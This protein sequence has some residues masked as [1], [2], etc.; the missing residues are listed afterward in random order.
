MFAH[1]HVHSSYSFLQALPGPRQLAEAISKSGQSGAALT[2]S[3][4]VAGLVEWFDELEKK[5]LRPVVGCELWIAESRL[6]G[7]D[8]RLPLPG[9]QVV[10]IA[11]TLEGWRGLCR[12][13]TAAHRRFDYC[14][15]TTLDDLRENRDGLVVLTGAEYGVTL[16]PDRALERT[17]ALR[18]AIGSSL[19]VEVFDLGLDGDGGR[20]A[21]ARSVAR[22]LSLP[23][24]A[25]ND[26]RY[27][28]PVEAAVLETTFQIAAGRPPSPE[29][30]IRTD[31]AYLKTE[32]EMAELFP[33]EELEESIR[34]LESCDFSP[35]RGVPM[36]PRVGGTG[37]RAS[38]WKYVRETFPPPEAFPKPP[39]EPPEEGP[40][41]AV[42]LRWYARE[43]LRIRLREHPET[44]SFA[45][46]EDHW[47]RLEMEL[48]VITQ[49]EY[50]TYH[51]IVAEFI[52]WAK[53]AGIQVGP[54]R[55]S[56]AGAIVCWALRITDCNPIQ[57]GLLF[58]RFLNPERRGLPDI[59]VDF[60]QARRE[61]VVVHVQG[62]Y[63]ADRVGQILTITRL[64][65]KSA[66][67]DAARVLGISFAEADQ[68]A[69]RI[70]E[71]PKVKLKD[72]LRDPYV[73]LARKCSPTHRRIFD[74]A[75][76]LEGIPRQLG[77]HAAG[78]IVAS[79][80]LQTFCPL[81]WNAKEGRLCVGLDMNS[82][83]KIGLVKFD[84]L[85]LKTLDVI[86]H[87]R[88]SVERRTGR[89]PAVEDPLYDDPDV[90]RMTT[91][92]DTL[93]MFQIESPGMIRLIRKMKPDRFDDLIAIL[94]LFRPGPLQSGMVDDYVERKHGRQETVH[95][96]K[97][98]E[99]TMIPTHGIMIYQEQALTSA[100][101]LAGY[102]YGEADLL[103]RAIGKKKAD[104]MAQQKG[105]FISGCEKNGI[106][107]S[108]AVRIF[109]L[110]DYFSGY[111]FNKCLSGS[112]LV[113]RAGAGRNAESPWISI[114]ELYE[115]QQS[116][117]PWGKKIRSGRLNLAQ[118]NEDARV[119]VGKMVRIYKVGVRPIFRVTTTHKT[120][121]GTAEHRLLS[122]AGY[123]QIGEIRPGETKLVCMGEREGY[124]RVG[125]KGR[126]KGTSY[127]ATEDGPLP[128]GEEN[129]G[130]IDGRHVTKTEAF[131]IVDTRANGRCE[132]CGIAP[133]SASSHALEHAHV[134]SLE[135]CTGNFDLYHSAENLLLLCNSCHKKFDYQK[136][137]RKARWSKGRPTHLEEVLSVEP[138]GETT[139][140]D[141]EME[142]PD[143][144][145]VA[146]GIISHNSH[147]AAYALITYQTAKL[148]VHYRADF[149]AAAMTF[150]A[151]NRGQLRAYVADA[152]R[153]G[154]SVLG[155][156]V[157]KSE[158]DFSVEELPSGALAVRYGLVAVK[159]LGGAALSSILTERRKGGPYRSIRDLADRTRLNKAALESV[160]WSGAADGIEPSRHDAWW[161]IT[162]PSH[163][164]LARGVAPE[165]I[166]LFS[167]KTAS[168][169]REEEIDEGRPPPPSFARRMMLEA[170]ALGTILSDHPL[171]RYRDVATRIR[172]HEIG[173]CPELQS[174]TPVILAG[175]VED[176]VRTKNKREDPYA[177]FTL[178]DGAASISAVIRGNAL[179]RI[180]KQHKIEPGD[181][182]RVEGTVQVDPD[183][184][185][186]LATAIEPLSATRER[187][188]RIL[189]ISIRGR[190]GVIR[191]AEL[192]GG[193]L[194][195]R[196]STS[197]AKIRIR[198][199]GEEDGIERV[200]ELPHKV[201]LSE[202]DLERIDEILGEPGSV[203]LPGAS[204]R[205]QRRRSG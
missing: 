202:E 46:E 188:S 180:E 72:S 147:S 113:M 77:V 197:G 49:M 28:E 29:G 102:S 103:R 99:E 118:M 171:R 67:K 127:A 39:S 42:Y 85:G 110:I 157:N 56:A 153:A 34:I 24:V 158:E 35:K 145:F 48:G 64:K 73:D 116:R 10:L 52:N 142:G 121:E 9:H 95:I 192:L 45:S 19:W 184:C 159:G 131:A 125:W 27:L 195:E 40:V 156:D 21:L 43:G 87:A 100:R 152:R 201:K 37:D 101:I 81:Q 60:E 32:A 112:T 139:V 26:V 168:E 204:K 63:G 182:L 94:A 170:T 183:S 185:Q 16:D 186:L 126:G 165:Q 82:A 200:A 90:F 89:R 178:E 143:H 205:S 93:G 164:R 177:R 17:R 117:T 83:E 190:A 135:D 108:E 50:S 25:T 199:V 18:D 107:E 92:A 8:P 14:P 47:A 54:G 137:E 86:E 11:R 144:N 69:K 133:E 120:I 174:G 13:V 61:E 4:S 111:S 80:P 176:I 98:L 163:K 88:K 97:L 140:Y 196:K 76:R 71:G 149:M 106:Q 154:L 167:G 179:A 66:V 68:I 151:N 6:D 162:R 136:G 38:E 12:I 55:G 7:S 138:I 20:C 41:D 191:S 119:R 203:R 132:Q 31:Q 59:D 146:N 169:E 75:L 128:E 65:A 96:H 161:S 155:P 79:D 62:K 74:L 78:V 84:F 51:L 189:E 129:P 36:L 193:L 134:K 91:A 122:E 114:Q 181:C 22:E 175:H 148:K 3:G 166:G 123:L 187:I 198:F 70:P 124:Q 109:Q 15:R 44:L 30:W 23:V 2:D 150:D 105:R 1:L 194:S 115:A 104:E 141:I 172:T 58:E 57:F 53:D 160:A 173:K 5:K 130:W 33:R